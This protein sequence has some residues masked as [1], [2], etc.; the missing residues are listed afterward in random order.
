MGWEEECNNCHCINGKVIVQRKCL[1]AYAGTTV[2]N[3][4]HE[5]R[6]LPDIPS[7]AKDHALLLLCD[8]FSLNQIQRLVVNGI[9]LSQTPQ[10]EDSPDHSDPEGQPAPIE[11]PCQACTTAC[12][13]GSH[14]V[15]GNAGH[16]PQWGAPPP[17]RD[18]SSAAVKKES[19][20][21]A[22]QSA[23]S[24]WVPPIDGSE[25]RGGGDYASFEL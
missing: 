14:Y 11:A 16:A 19:N 12:N 25:G 3:I 1:C 10:P 2:E 4:W 8:I 21:E 7:L 15:S 24:S 5:L 20:R 6:Y 22:E 18:A 17:A 23:K 9:K 13:A